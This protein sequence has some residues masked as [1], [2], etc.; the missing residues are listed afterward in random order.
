MKAGTEMAVSLIQ[1]WT[2]WTMVT[3]RMPPAPT[4]ARTIAA[5][6]VRPTHG[7]APATVAN[8]SPAPWNCGSR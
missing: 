3:E 1:Y 2:A 4:A 8:V 5:T 7:G 6:T